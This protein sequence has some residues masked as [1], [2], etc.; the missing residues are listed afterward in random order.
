MT[1][2]LDN[3]IHSFKEVSIHLFNT[4]P[5]PDLMSTD[6][7][8]DGKKVTA[9]IKDFFLSKVMPCDLDSWI[10]SFKEVSFHLFNT[11]TSH[12]LIWC[13]LTI[14]QIRRNKFQGNLNPN[15]I[16]FIMK[17][18]LKMSSAKCQPSCAGLTLLTVR[19]I[20]T[21][22][23]P[24]NRLISTM[25]FPILARWHLYIESGHR[26]SGNLNILSMLFHIPIISGQL[27]LVPIQQSVNL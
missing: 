1:C 15:K 23:T 8:S 9:I 18:L 20:I 7:Q 4:K 14:D 13:Q 5:S 3:W 6:Y 26:K 2:D 22:R 24:D 17:M 25:G 11:N 21:S 19:I 10:F 27:I 12:P 16:N